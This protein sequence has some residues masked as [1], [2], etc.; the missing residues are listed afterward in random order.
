[1]DVEAP[2]DGPGRAAVQARDRERA[3]AAL[4]ARVLEAAAAVASGLGQT[5]HV[6][7]AW[8]AP[9]MPM[10]GRVRVDPDRNRR[11]FEEGL[12][13]AAERVE[14]IL[15]AT[16]VDVSRDRIHLARAP[17]RSAIPDVA[18]STGA[19]VLVIGEA[20][21][22]G[23]G[24]GFDSGVAGHLLGAVRCSLV[25]V[26]AEAERERA[27]WPARAGVRILRPQDR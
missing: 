20:R 11:A 4:D 12:L 3:A 17:P 25:V 15:A 14:R 22:G 27:R 6:V 23:A 8:A 10:L 24:A 9:W 5:L 21:R 2:G 19:Q 1:V 16:G 7:H 18:A 13:A 26:R